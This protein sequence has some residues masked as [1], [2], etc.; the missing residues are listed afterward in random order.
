MTSE[1]WLGLTALTVLL[2]AGAVAGLKR[3]G[4]LKTLNI[5]WHFRLA[6]TGLA[7]LVLHV[8]T[9]LAGW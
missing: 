8:V 9:G 4:L 6:Y 2:T 7:L 5:K 3:K 1:L